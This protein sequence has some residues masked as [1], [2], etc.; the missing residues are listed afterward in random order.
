MIHK[1][2]TVFFAMEHSKLTNSMLLSKKK[3][4]WYFKAAKHNERNLGQGQ[5]KT[6]KVNGTNKKLENN[7]STKFRE[8]TRFHFRLKKCNNFKIK[9]LNGKLE[10]LVISFTAHIK[11][12]GFQTRKEHGCLF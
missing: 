1:S 8:P 3:L 10:K 5:Q 11:V 6:A 9:L 12:I 7:F 2:Y 4:F